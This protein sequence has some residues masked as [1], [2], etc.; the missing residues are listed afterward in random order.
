[1]HPP[2]PGP[3]SG[4]SS[5][6]DS[7][8]EFEADRATPAF[9]DICIIAQQLGWPLLYFATG[10]ERS[11][12]DPRTAVAHLRAWGLSDLRVSE[13]VLLGELRPFEEIIP[14]VVS[15][16]VDQ[17][18]LAALP[19]LLLRNRFEP[20]RLIAAA[21]ALGSLRRLGWI[22]D[23]ARHVSRRLPPSALQPDYQ[24]R[25]SAIE[26]AAAKEFRTSDVTDRD[27]LAPD[28]STSK[29]ARDRLWKESPPMTRRWR[30]ACD[31]RLDEFVERARSL[32]GR[33]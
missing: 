9:D 19:A 22:A 2:S 25:L 21:Q 15:R 3:D 32:L 11:A 27:Y 26:A 14:D 20:T 8:E 6:D 28:L 7:P 16:P 30:I 18:V 1:M 12:D 29:S 17:R 23:V 4:G 13:P 31:I 5:P 33:E 10:Q 24:R